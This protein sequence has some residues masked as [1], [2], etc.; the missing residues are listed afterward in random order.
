MTSPISSAITDPTEGKTVAEH[1]T[2]DTAHLLE[3]AEEA[4]T[5]IDTVVVL[6]FGSQYSQLIT[7][8]VR[9]C[10][11]YCELMHHDTAWDEVS[12]LD[13]KGIILSGGPA[14]VYADDAPTLPAWV[15]ERE[16]PVLGICYGM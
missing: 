2:D 16:L 8:R 14:S 12:H 7:R 1:P 15:L 3:L 5:A 6:D 10:G 11:V 4:G 13:P 9:E